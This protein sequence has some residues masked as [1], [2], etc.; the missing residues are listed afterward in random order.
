[1]PATHFGRD[2]L[3]LRCALCHRGVHW[4][5]QCMVTPLWVYQGDLVAIW[6]LLSCILHTTT[7]RLL[8]PGLREN[9]CYWLRSFGLAANL[10]ISKPGAP[11]A[12]LHF[13]PHGADSKLHP[14][15]S[16]EVF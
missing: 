16:E 9:G 10:S 12:N 1:M 8:L 2:H 7:L 5:C 3:V 14:Y 4:V 6:V 15:D 13:V 11:S